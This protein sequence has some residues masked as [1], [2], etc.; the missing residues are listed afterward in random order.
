MHNCQIRILLQSIPIKEYGRLKQSC[1]IIMPTVPVPL[2][3]AHGHTAIPEDEIDQ[4]VDLSCHEMDAVTDYDG[5][6]S[7]TRQNSCC[8]DANGKYGQTTLAHQYLHGSRGLSSIAQ[9]SN[10]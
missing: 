2:H 9:C 1:E 4:V 8:M 10:W 3:L 7:R 5:M 6:E